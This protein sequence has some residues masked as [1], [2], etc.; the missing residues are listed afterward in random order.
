MLCDFGLSRIR[1]EVSRT[2]TTIHQGGRQR[3]IAP[4]ISS[5][6]ESRINE[7]SDIYSLAMTI[8]ALGTRSMP[9]TRI[10][11]DM[12]ACQ[13]A[14]A[15]ERPQKPDSLGGLTV[16][17]T[18]FLW[19]L[20][21]G[22]WNHI[23]PL[24]P[25]V[26]TIRDEIMRSD[27]TPLGV[28]AVP[29]TVSTSTPPLT[30]TASYQNQSTPPTIPNPPAPLHKNTAQPLPGPANPPSL[31]LDDQSGHNSRLPPSQLDLQDATDS[32]VDAHPSPRF[33][34]S[35]SPSPPG[36]H[37]AIIRPPP[38]T[39]SPSF[40]DKYQQALPG[41]RA[42]QRMSI[43]PG[44]TI[45]QQTRRRPTSLGP[46]MPPQEPFAGISEHE[47]SP[48]LQP[49]QLPSPVTTPAP[50]SNSPS[51]AQQS[52]RPPMQTPPSDLRQIRRSAST[53]GIAM[54]A[55]RQVN[56]GA[57]AED[58][59]RRNQ[60]RHQLGTSSHPSQQLAGPSVRAYPTGPSQGPYP[61][62]ATQS[63]PRSGQG[64][65]VAADPRT[66]Q[67]QYGEKA[68]ATKIPRPVYGAPTIISSAPPSSRPQV[69]QQRLPLVRRRAMAMKGHL[70][71]QVEY[72]DQHLQQPT[73]LLPLRIAPPL[74][75]PRQ[76]RGRQ[77]Q[78][79]QYYSGHTYAQQPPQTVQPAHAP[80]D[81]QQPLVNAYVPQNQSLQTSQIGH[82]QPDD[83][84]PNASGAPQPPL[85]QAAPQHMHQR[86]VYTQP[87]QPV[88]RQQNPNQP[89]SNQQPLRT[90]SPSSRSTS[91]QDDHP[92]TETL[93]DGTPVLFY[94]TSAS[95][96][97]RPAPLNPI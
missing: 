90:P 55:R 76:P 66:R 16:N 58:Y 3:F 81:Q 39:P 2:H 51:A 14:R 49:M 60:M 57:P 84:F 15:G 69:Q 36:P 62:P 85:Q 13:A 32:I 19:V 77:P 30:P 1:H 48:T 35:A 46:T 52:T 34:S 82:G 9:F 86:T 71:G 8:Y 79:Q 22:M 41:E 26:S 64:P 45:S 4:E 24:R 65:A 92:G 88:Q 96:M 93:E 91:P 31:V 75:P 94:G 33:P 78:R 56:H 37:V 68:G 42:E 5:G 12:A 47:K 67:V 20:M 18:A 27:L 44:E 23:P 43:S 95:F 21:E 89:V 87:Q 97:P 63:R 38:R 50:T 70:E 6:M 72:T 53:T 28:T 11:N 25:M 10:A 80:P 17:D 59:A 73:G 29:V 54:D 61:P 40:L 7:R 74:P 83:S